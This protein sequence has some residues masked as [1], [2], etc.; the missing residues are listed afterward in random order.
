MERHRPMIYTIKVHKM[1]LFPCA[2]ALRAIDI[3]KNCAQINIFKRSLKELSAF[4]PT[5]SQIEQH[6]KAI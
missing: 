4:A 5:A 3:K 2:V 6:R 1:V